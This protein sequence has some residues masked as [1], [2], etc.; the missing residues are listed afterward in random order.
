[1]D[2]KKPFPRDL[3]PGKAENKADGAACCRCF[4]SG[5][6]A[7]EEGIHD[8]GEENKDVDEVRQCLDPLHPGASRAFWS[9]V[10][11]APADIEDGCRN[12]DGQDGAWYHIPEKELADGLARVES[13]DHEHDAR[14]YEDPEGCAGGNRAGIQLGW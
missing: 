6:N 1:M 14:R 8:D 2:V 13:V 5:N 4:R 7:C 12:E 9:P 11:V 3:S 10:R